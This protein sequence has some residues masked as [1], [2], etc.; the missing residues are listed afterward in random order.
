MAKDTI[1]Q[2]HEP[3]TPDGVLNQEYNTRTPMTQAESRDA[4]LPGLR[5]N[6]EAGVSNLPPGFHR[7]KHY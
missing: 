4:Y 1:F 7:G 2:S 3:M 5:K 6:Y